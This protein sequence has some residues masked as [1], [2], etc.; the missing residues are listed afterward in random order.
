MINTNQPS[1]GEVLDMLLETYEAPTQEAVAHF[2]ERYPALRTDLI[3]F[4]AAWAQEAHLTLPPALTSDQEARVLSRAQSFLENQLFVRAPATAAATSLMG[5]IRAAGASVRDLANATGLN[6]ALVTKLNNRLI[7][8][9]TVPHRLSAAIADFLGVE[10]VQVVRSW[11][12]SPR[13]SASFLAERE[14][15]VEQDDFASAVLGSSLSAEAKEALLR[16]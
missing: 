15:A 10:V 7:R 11:S 4:A 12:A 2:S 3:G 14:T 1:L 6:T 9:D 16:D 5:L 8:P 13:L